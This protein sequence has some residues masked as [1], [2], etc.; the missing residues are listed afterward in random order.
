MAETPAPL[1]EAEMEQLATLQARAEAAAAAARSA[2][3]TT[4]QD[5]VSGSNFKGALVEMEAALTVNPKDQDL[6]Y[7]INMMERMASRFRT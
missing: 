5:L 3:Q 6:V 4:M 1:S 7:A 2:I